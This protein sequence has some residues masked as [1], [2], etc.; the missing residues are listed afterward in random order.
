MTL[1]EL[2]LLTE[3]DLEGRVELGRGEY[4][5]L[6]SAWL[7]RKLIIDS[8]SLLTRVNATRREKLVFRVTDIQ[9]GSTVIGWSPGEFLAP[10]PDADVASTVEL[11]LKQFL[12]HTTLIAN[13]HKVS[14]KDLVKFMANT[15]GAVHVSPVNPKDA[16]LETL[17]GVRWGESRS[18]PRGQY[19]GCIHEL[20]AIGR[21]VIATTADLR[22]Q[23]EQETWHEEMPGRP[24]GLRRPARPGLIS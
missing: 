13:G 7:I 12:A 4:D 2:F 6:M 24:R 22:Q 21:I 16:K 10:G 11:N 14:V 20:V 23:I 3:E 18:D 8:P 19:G 1:D 5:A 15:E 9:P 17:A